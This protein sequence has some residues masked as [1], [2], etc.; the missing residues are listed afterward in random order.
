M[1]YQEQLRDRRWQIKRTKILTRD[2]YLCQNVN[3][4]HRDDHSVLIE[5]HHLEYIDNTMAWDYPDDML[6]SLCRKCHESEQLRPKEEKYLI[7]TLRMKGFLVSDLLAHS[8]LIDTDEKF[9]QSLLK[10]LREFQ[11][12]QNG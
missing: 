9:T 5:V 1:T 7:N 2:N 6:V 10:V 12:R 4:K 11:T 3:C 8:V